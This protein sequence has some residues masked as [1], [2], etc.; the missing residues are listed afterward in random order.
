M[1]T[2]IGTQDNNTAMAGP[3][4]NPGFLIP[5]LS[6]LKSWCSQCA[7]ES[8][9]GLNKKRWLSLTPGVSDS[10]RLGRGLLIQI[11]KFPGGADAAGWEHSLEKQW[12]N[13]LSLCVN[14]NL[15]TEGPVSH[16]L[17]L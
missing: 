11:S 6:L 4:L 7:S 16:H 14:S 10:V 17:E 12:T 1:K 9:A 5:A 8:P 15:S 3:D 13:T 2:G